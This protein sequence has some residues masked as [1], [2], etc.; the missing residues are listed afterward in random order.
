MK[1]ISMDNL[2]VALALVHLGQQLGTDGPVARTIYD[3]AT[4]A[5]Y[6]VRL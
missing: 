2:I 4:L 5:L 3:L 6:C 1:R